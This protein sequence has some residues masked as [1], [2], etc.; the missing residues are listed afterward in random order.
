MFDQFKAKHGGLGPVQS[1]L[2]NATHGALSNRLRVEA[3]AGQMDDTLASIKDDPGLSDDFKSHAGELLRHG[4][5]DVDSAIKNI[6]G[7]QAEAQ[8]QRT[9]ART[10]APVLD[11]ARALHEGATSPADKQIL[12]S[13]LANAQAAHELALDPAT[14]QQGMQMF[15]TVAQDVTNFTVKNKENE[16]AAQTKAAE[17]ERDLSK[18][19]LAAY[20]NTR[21][22]WQKDSAT[23]QQIGTAWRSALE[24][25][26]LKEPTPATD[27]NLLRVA[28]EIFN[29][30]GATRPGQDPGDVY[31]DAIPFGLGAAVKYATT[32]GTGLTSSDRATLLYAMSQRVK[33]ENAAQMQRNTKALEEGRAEELPEKY[34][35][36]LTAPAIDLGAYGVAREPTAPTPAPPPRGGA[37]S[38]DTAQPDSTGAM[39]GGA[40][41]DTA[42]DLYNG[43]VDFSDELTGGMGSKMARGITEQQKAKKRAA[44]ATT[45]TDEYGEQ[46]VMTTG[47]GFQ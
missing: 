39:I 2:D 40:V 16:V 45:R 5:Y 44:A 36:L 46:H 22:N 12:S 24:I 11:G 41:K 1:L 29:P 15:G 32:N 18:S 26:A 38:Q 28:G 47:G 25:G 23:N 43:L 42:L 10:F 3:V 14:R 20:Q 9:I 19:Q 17:A 35:S 13:L 6:G 7:V 37:V 34:L 31:Y 33:E 8:A 21:E 27:Q 4:V 30:S